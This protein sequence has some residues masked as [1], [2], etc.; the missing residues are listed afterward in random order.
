[1]IEVIR[2]SF[3]TGGNQQKL[4]GVKNLI[5]QQEREG[6][7]EIISMDDEVAKVRFV[8]PTLLK[9]FAEHEAEFGEPSPSGRVH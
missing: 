9:I 5:R 4:D 1:M 8:D 6:I 7:L 3:L 2:L